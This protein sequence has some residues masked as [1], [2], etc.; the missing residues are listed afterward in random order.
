MTI[1]QT[2][3]PVTDSDDTGF[4][5]RP[6]IRT[7]RPG[8]AVPF[9]RML[10]VLAIL[11]AWGAGSALHLLDD[12]KLAAPWTVVSDA[13]GM[14]VDGSLLE[15]IGYSLVRV[16]VGVSCGVAIGVALALIAG[17]SRLGEYFVDGPVQLKRAI[18]SLG[19]IPL[20]ILWLG[21]DELFKIVL[22]VI[23]VAV[24]MYIQVYGS[25]TSIEERFIELAEIQRVDRGTFIRRVVIPGSLPGFF[26]GLRLSVTGAWMY[27]V[28][29]E[30]VNATDGLGKLMS[31]AQNYGQSSVILVCLAVYGIFGL[32]ADATIRLIEHK[33]LSWR[34]TIS[35]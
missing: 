1:A 22:I 10:G 14:L 34:R 12:R 25:V 33:V 27:L 31:D 4:V 3:P 20:M 13:W 30:S 26:L 32:M 15:H 21:I 7:L 5:E 16:V 28:V 9:G 18:P 17:L 29:V 19:L 6:R 11:V 2:R 24:H 35:S 23:G 8:R